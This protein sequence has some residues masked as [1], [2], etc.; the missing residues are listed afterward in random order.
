MEQPTEWAGERELVMLRDEVIFL[1]HTLAL[2]RQRLEVVEA[3]AKTLQDERPRRP[4]PRP[5]VDDEALQQ[6]ILGVL[7]EVG[8]PLT[9]AM[10]RAKLNGGEASA[11]V[12]KPMVNGNLRAMERAK[13]A[14]SR[15]G[16]RRQVL[17]SNVELK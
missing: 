4:A 1:T 15:A 11:R 14:Y 10:I 3:R 13:K 5:V 7:T 8:A 12:T 17:W 9:S 6:R 2:V 16:A